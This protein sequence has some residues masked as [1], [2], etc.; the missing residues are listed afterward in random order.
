MSNH[1]TGFSI[2]F[3]NKTV[4]RYVDGNK[5]FRYSPLR[6]P[7]PLLDDLS[8]NADAHRPAV[9]LLIV[10]RRAV[11]TRSKLS[12]LVDRLQVAE[13]LQR[14]PVPGDRR[15]ADIVLTEN[16]CNALRR[17]WPADARAIQRR[18]AG[19]LADEEA[20]LVAAV[21]EQVLAETRRE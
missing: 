5:A 19:Y 14:E 4:S 6:R 15:G 12:R 16:G 8:G 9:G 2:K 20:R 13:L 11:L 1:L 7:E 10:A 18:F 21:L 3:D 17:A